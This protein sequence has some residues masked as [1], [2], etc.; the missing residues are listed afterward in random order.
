MFGTKHRGVSAYANV[1]LETGV[2]AASPHKLIVMLFDGALVAILSGLTA[3]NQG[4]VAAKGAALSKAINIIDNGLRAALDKKAGGEI[5]VNLDAL[6]EYISAL[7]LRGNIDNDSAK[8]EEA[9][10]LLSG[11]RDAWSQ[12]G[13]D[14]AAAPAPAPAAN[15]TLRPATLM[16][17]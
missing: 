5:A 14:G 3:M 13:P 8:L 11:L 16:S 4:N 15:A 10:K 17:A 12:I 1:G 6:Y 7:L 2:T 9:H